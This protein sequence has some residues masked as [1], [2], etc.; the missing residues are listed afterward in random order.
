MTAQQKKINSAILAI[1]KI[2]PGM[3]IGLGTGSTAKEF[4]N[5]LGS[6][7]EL[8]KTIKC[9]STSQQTELLAKKNNIQC[10]SLSSFDSLDI[11]IDGADEIDRYGNMIKGGGGALLREKILASMSKSYLIIVDEA[12]IVDQ[13]G[14]FPL[15]IEIIAFSPEK[16]INMIN[17]V[18]K[19]FKMFPNVEIR[20]NDKGD[21]FITDGSNL[22]VDCYCNN[23]ESPETINQSLE[24]IPNVITTGLFINMA[25]SYIVGY[26]D[27]AEEVHI[28]QNNMS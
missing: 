13:L 17:D 23:I 25:N 8:C 15:P 28:N 5:I 9:A 2:K 16:A 1:E 21:N 18:F 7:P 19:K 11:T 4:I 22:I 10:Y 12:K 26:E 20:K 6:K 27:R 14:S 24:K 3:K